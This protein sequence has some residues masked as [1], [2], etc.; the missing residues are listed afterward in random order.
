MVGIGHH[1]HH[2][3]KKQQY[4]CFITQK[5]G[6]LGGEGGCGKDTVPVI[7]I[8]IDSL[9]STTVANL[10][11]LSLKREVG[12]GGGVEFSWATLIINTGN[13]QHF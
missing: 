3:L 13:I 2:G 10:Q 7:I 4:F 9:S 6:G 1:H 5:V 8:I 11:A 12:C